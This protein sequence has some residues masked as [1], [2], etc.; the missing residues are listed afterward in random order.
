MKPLKIIFNTWTLQ[1]SEHSAVATNADG[2]R[3]EVHK[4]TDFESTLRL[5]RNKVQRNNQ[6]A[7]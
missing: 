4:A 3:A 1:V 5:I 7:K 6:E 2:E